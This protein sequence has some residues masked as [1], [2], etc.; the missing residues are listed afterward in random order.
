MINASSSGDHLDCFLA[1]DS[2]VWAGCKRLAGTEA[3][4]LVIDGGGADGPDTGDDAIDMGG[5]AGPEGTTL[6]G[7]ADVVVP[8]GLLSSSSCGFRSSEISTLAEGSKAGFCK[9]IICA[10]RKDVRFDR[11]VDSKR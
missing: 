4:I 5:S 11:E 8:G 9:A 10:T 2:A 1:G 3:G 7:S 6:D